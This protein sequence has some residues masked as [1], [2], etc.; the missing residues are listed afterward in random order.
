MAVGEPASVG[1]FAAV[2]ARIVG[3][4]DEESA[5]KALASRALREAELVLVSEDA[6]AAARDE[7]ADLRKAARGAVLVVPGCRGT[8]GAA[9][10]EIRRLVINAVGVD[11]VA[12]AA[13][14]AGDE[15]AAA[16]PETTG[17]GAI[18]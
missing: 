9:L 15:Q 12:R 5:R 18:R 10:E 13:D 14:R 3:A 11:L 6:A 1:P 8:K 7:M 2:G 17:L 16:K 4:P